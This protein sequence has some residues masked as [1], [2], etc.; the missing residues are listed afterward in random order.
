M[1]AL[2]LQHTTSPTSTVLKSSR[3]IKDE[4]LWEAR[5]LRLFHPK[6]LPLC[7]DV[8]ALFVEWIDGRVMDGAN[9]ILILPL[10]FIPRSRCRMRP[11]V[12]PMAATTASLVCHLFLMNWMEVSAGGY[13]IYFFHFCWTFS[14]GSALYFLPHALAGILPHSNH[15]Q[16]S[17]HN[18]VTM[19]LPHAS[20]IAPTTMP[21]QPQI[22]NQ[23]FP[24]T[25]HPAFPTSMGPLPAACPV[26]KHSS[27]YNAAPPIIP[28]PPSTNN[29]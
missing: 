13:P 8:L 21:N 20:F 7:S 1:R 17:Y 16:Y 12:V 6:L 18:N 15:P 23:H 28:T 14:N 19:N 22:L 9:W 26:P 5:A 10:I 27:H 29:T 11:W 25:S 2:R 3:P 24:T 4:K